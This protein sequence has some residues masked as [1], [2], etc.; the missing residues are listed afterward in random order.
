MSEGRE[1]IF[2]F[3]R[4][5]GAVKVC[6]IDPETGI[7]AAIVADPAAGEEALTRLAQQKLDYVLAKRKAG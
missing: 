7:E 4:L 2:E 6:A 5:G 1:T 3:I